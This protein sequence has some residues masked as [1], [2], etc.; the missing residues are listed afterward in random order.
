MSF[1]DRVIR[2]FVGLV[3]RSEIVERVS[4]WVLSEFSRRAKSLCLQLTVVPQRSESAVL[5]RSPERSG[6]HYR[7]TL[8]SCPQAWTRADGVA[9]I[10]GSRTGLR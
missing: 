1:G 7:S 4:Y 9:Q 3:P 5:G 6:E 8:P 10:A 2:P